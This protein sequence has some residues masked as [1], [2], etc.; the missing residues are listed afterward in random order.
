MGA[1]SAW[2]PNATVYSYWTISVGSG[3]VLTTNSVM[4]PNPDAAPLSAYHHHVLGQQVTGNDSAARDM[5]G[6]AAYPKQIGIFGAARAADLP[7]GRH[8]LDFEDVVQRGTP[9]A[10]HGAQPSLDGKVSSV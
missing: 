10:R 4:T 1:I 2:L 6:Y 5:G 3:W 8:D 7:V 9:H